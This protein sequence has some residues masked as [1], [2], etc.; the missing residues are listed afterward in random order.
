MIRKWIALVAAAI[1]AFSMIG[2]GL[3]EIIPPVGEGQIGLGALVLCEGVTLRENPDDASAAVAELVF[4]DHVIVMKQE[5]GWAQCTLS[6]SIDEDRIGWLKAD[7]LMIDPSWYVTEE[8][9]TPVYAW[10]DASAPRVAFFAERTILPILRD[11]GEWLV[12]SV[13]GAT[14]WILKTAADWAPAE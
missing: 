7:A 10:N 3:A 4:G 2:T 11:A 12:V 1:A 14:G 5:D 6:D 9:G 8:E 13:N